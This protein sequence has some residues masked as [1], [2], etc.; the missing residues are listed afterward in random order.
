[1]DQ[2]PDKPSDTPIV[3]LEVFR[4]QKADASAGLPPGCLERVELSPPDLQR[5]LNLDAICGIALRDIGII[6]EQL[7]TIDLQVQEL[8]AKKQSLLINLRHQR[9]VMLRDLE[10][11]VS[12]LGIDTRDPSKA[13]TFLADQRALFRTR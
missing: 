11:S 1:M 4:G 9:T 5:L 12:R 7:S 6:E 10:V 13:W 3:N 2:P 8:S